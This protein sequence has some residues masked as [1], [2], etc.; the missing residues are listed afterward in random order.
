MN[1]L[2]MRRSLIACLLAMFVDTSSAVT[3]VTSTFDTGNEGWQPWM[4]G[5]AN[6]LTPNNPYL[7]IAADGD[8]VFGKAITVNSTVAWTGDYLTAGVTE[9]RLNVANMSEIDNLRL[10][11]AIGNRASP[12]QSGGS[13]W[14]S[15][16]PIV[17]S[18]VTGSSGITWI[19]ATISL[20][21][22]DLVRVGNEVGELGTDT[23]EETFRDIR[24]IRILSSNLPLAAIGDEFIGTVA[25]DNIRLAVPEPSIPIFLLLATG[26][27]IS[28]RTRESV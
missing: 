15:A 16:D 26:L 20:R 6:G 21:E 28:R 13:W 17:L 22:S 18:A 8:G 10:R 14:V 7:A 25:L 4:T 5:T 12:M 3:F 19:E 27:A 9:L 11:V 24:N 23:Y 1:L 2:S